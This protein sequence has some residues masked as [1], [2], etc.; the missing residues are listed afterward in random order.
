MGKGL[1]GIIRTAFFISENTVKIKNITVMRTLE[2][3]FRNL[4][5]GHGFESSA[6]ALSYNIQLYDVCGNIVKE[7]H[8]SGE[9]VVW[10]LTELHNGIY[11]VLIKDS[12]EKVY[13]K[14]FYKD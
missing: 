6:T 11:V 7:G 14:T 9:K 12:R 3:S 13:S 2:V 4:L 1:S 8:S 10:N 5:S